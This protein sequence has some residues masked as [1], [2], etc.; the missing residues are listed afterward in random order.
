MGVFFEGNEGDFLRIN[1]LLDG[2]PLPPD[3]F[4]WVFDGQTLTNDTSRL[5]FGV[6]YIQ[7]DPLLRGDRGT[8]TVTATNLAGTGQATFDLESYCK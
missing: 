4:T 7:F 1:L 5:T 3:S 2:L 6:D 8:Y